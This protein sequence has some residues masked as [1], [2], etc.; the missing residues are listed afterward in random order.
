[1]A[2]D[3]KLSSDDKP[4]NGYRYSRKNVGGRATDANRKHGAILRPGTSKRSAR[5]IR[6]RLRQREALQLRLRGR[7]YEEIAKATGVTKSTAERDISDAMAAVIREPAH[8]VFQAEMLRLD[9]L[10][11]AHIDSALEGNVDATYAVLA[12]ARHRAQLLNWIGAGREPAARLMIDDAGG[13][14]SLA[15]EFV[16]PSGNKM[17]MDDL[18]RSPSSLPS[19]G[20]RHG[21][22]HAYHPDKPSPSPRRIT[23]RQDDITLERVIPDS[24]KKR[25]GFAWE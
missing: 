3:T 14:R 19:H 21:N 23:P 11:S 5:A 4:D 8:L 10:T 1:M 20:N 13:A 7:S 17:S 18:P 6:I 9:Q 25:H 22:D 12:I 16:L 15:I 24:F 2:D